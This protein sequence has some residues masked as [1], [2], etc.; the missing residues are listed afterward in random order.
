MIDHGRVPDI[1]ETHPISSTPR[2]GIDHPLV[3]VATQPQIISPASSSRPLRHARSPIPSQR[4]Q[5]KSSGDPQ[6]VIYHQNYE[7]DTSSSKSEDSDVLEVTGPPAETPGSNPEGGP[8]S[9]IIEDTPESSVSPSTYAE[10]DFISVQRTASEIHFDPS[11]AHDT[12]SGY[13]ATS[14]GAVQITALLDRK[15]SEN[16]IS[17]TLATKLGLQ[18]YDSDEEKDAKWICIGKVTRKKS[19]GR[20]ILRWSQG[21]FLDHAPLKVHCWVYEDDGTR[22]LVFGTPFVDKRRHYWQATEI[23]E[24]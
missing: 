16:I 20:V 6:V 5:P 22:D 15:L 18:L 10:G 7:E 21:A 13:A 12:I 23:V 14:K 11:I 1:G 8:R 2:T 9:L 19:R 3:Q 4:L 24:G 17:L